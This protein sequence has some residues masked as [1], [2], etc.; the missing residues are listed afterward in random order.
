[1]S[2]QPPASLPSC[3]QQHILPKHSGMLHI[4][5]QCVLESPSLYIFQNYEEYL[6]IDEY[7][8]MQFLQSL[9]ALFPS[10]CWGAYAF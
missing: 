10:P 6:N 2:E 9:A 4:F 1:M 7:I 8:E 5:S 3:L